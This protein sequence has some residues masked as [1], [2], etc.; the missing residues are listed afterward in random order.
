MFL[1]SSPCA[2]WLASLSEQRRAPTSFRVKVRRGGSDRRS[3]R[4]EQEPHPDRLVSARSLASACTTMC[5]AAVLVVVGRERRISVLL[6]DSNRG[7]KLHGDLGKN[8]LNQIC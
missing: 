6:I 3:I 5:S 4:A 1:A 8:P 2:L 7:G